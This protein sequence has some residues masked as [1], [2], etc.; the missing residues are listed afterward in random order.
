MIGRR[1]SKWQGA[2]SDFVNDVGVFLQKVMWL[3]ATH[4][5]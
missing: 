2:E 1:R 5:K 4:R 3:H